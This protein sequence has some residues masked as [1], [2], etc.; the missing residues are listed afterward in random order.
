MKPGFTYGQ[1]D[2][3]SFH[4]VENH[5]P[6]HDLNATALHLMG[7]NRNI[8]PTASIVA[9]SGSPILPATSS[10]RYCYEHSLLLY[11]KI[12]L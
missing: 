10:R 8:S 2:E 9:I 3:W 6:V 1:T 12:L 5:V 7:I 11:L 4:A